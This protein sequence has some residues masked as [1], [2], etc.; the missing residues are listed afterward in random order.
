VFGVESGK[1]CVGKVFEWWDGAGWMNLGGGWEAKGVRIV[2]GALDSGISRIFR[3]V[4]L[5]LSRDTCVGDCG[6]EVHVRLGW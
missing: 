4:G 5:C 2:D 6:V 1:C 3:V